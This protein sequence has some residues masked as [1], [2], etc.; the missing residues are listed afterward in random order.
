MIE[1]LNSDIVYVENMSLA[2]DG[3]ILLYTIGVILK[4][5]GK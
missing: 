1:R 4:G 5:K 3:K 2:L